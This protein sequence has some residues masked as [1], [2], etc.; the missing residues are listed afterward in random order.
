MSRQCPLW[1]QRCDDSED[2]VELD[3]EQEPKTSNMASWAKSFLEEMEEQED[4]DDLD[5]DE[6]N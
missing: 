5:E 2:A 1:M 4:E 3:E 6:E